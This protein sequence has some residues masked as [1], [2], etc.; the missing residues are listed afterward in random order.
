[1]IDLI[2]H[3][4]SDLGSPNVTDSSRRSLCTRCVFI[5]VHV[6]GTT[7]GASRGGVP[8]TAAVIVAVCIS[9]Q[10]S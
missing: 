6:V 5:D 7:T 9:Y 3:L 4:I 1:M 10:P 2:F 8:K